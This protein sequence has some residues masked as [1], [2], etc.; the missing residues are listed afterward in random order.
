MSV[1]VLLLNDVPNLGQAGATV[2]VAPGYARNFLVPQG[3][4]E[5]VTEAAKRRLAFGRG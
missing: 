5:P 2:R 1:E 4:A 3:L